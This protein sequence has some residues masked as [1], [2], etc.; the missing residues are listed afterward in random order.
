MSV[1]LFGSC[2]NGLLACFRFAVG[3]VFANSTVKQQRLLR[4]V[5]YGAAQAV[6]SDFV[7]VLLIDQNLPMLHL[8]KTKKQAGK[9]RFTTTA[10]PHKADFFS[11]R[12]FQAEIG[13]YFLVIRLFLIRK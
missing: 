11:G 7:N 10:W 4:H 5:R 2:N 9:C 3:Y 13:K 6:L 8:V 12:N 1:G